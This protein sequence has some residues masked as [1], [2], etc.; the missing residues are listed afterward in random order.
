[1]P[2]FLIIVGLALILTAARGKEDEL[3]AILKDD[4]T[5]SNNF[6]A[7]LAAFGAIGFVGSISKDIRPAT[8]AFSAL[9]LVVL[10]AGHK[11]FFEQFQRQALQ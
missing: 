1:M 5:S 9:L 3:V 4:F 7:W 8:D 2:I 10:I 6:V 11:G